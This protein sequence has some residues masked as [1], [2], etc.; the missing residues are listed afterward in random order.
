MILRWTNL[1]VGIIMGVVISL[2]AQSVLAQ[3]TYQRLIVMDERVGVDGSDVYIIWD[4]VE[5]TNCYVYSYR[6]GISC[7]RSKNF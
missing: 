2:T 1:I 7:V 4:D 3:Y 6:G 5:K